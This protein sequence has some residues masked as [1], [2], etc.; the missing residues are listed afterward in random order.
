MMNSRKSWVNKALLKNIV[1]NNLFPAK[2]SLIIFVGFFILA[3]ISADGTGIGQLCIGLFGISAVVLTTVYPCFIQSFLINKTKSSMMKSIPLDSRTVWFTNYLAGYLIV[4]VTLLMEGIG[5]VFIDFT[6]SYNLVFSGNMLFRF[7]LM[8]FVL[9]F[10]YYTITFLVSSMAGNRLG[11]IVFSIVVYTLPVVLLGSFIVF[12]TYLVPG[13]VNQIENYYINMLFPLA[14]GL[15][16]ISIGNLTII[17]H[18]FIALALLGLSYYVYKNRDDEYIDEPLVFNKIGIVLKSGIVLIVTITVFYLILLFSHIDITFGIKGMLMLLTI[19]LIIGIIIA[20]FI[21]IIFKSQYIYRKLLIY[22]P[23]LLIFFGVNYIIANGQYYKAVNEVTGKSDVVGELYI[24]DAKSENTFTMNIEHTQLFDM[25]KYLND[26]RDNI[27]FEQVENSN[28]IIVFNLYYEGVNDNYHD[29]LLQY[30]FDQKLLIDYFKKHENAYLSSNSFNF[31]KES[32]LTCYYDNT[33]I[34]LNSSETKQLY[35]MTKEQNIVV[36]DFFNGE[37]IN[38]FGSSGNQYI[39]KVNDKFHE[40]LKDKKLIGQTEF[41][42]RCNKFIYD[43]TLLSDETDNKIFQ[44]VKEQLNIETFTLY[45][46]GIE[47]IEFDNNYVTY[48]MKLTIVD[49]TENH[50]ITLIIGLENEDD[51]IIIN[52]INR[53]AGE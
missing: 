26:N 40:F 49:E 4:L 6:R 18:C 35:Q 24:F 2:I 12:T 43:E 5:I 15:E 16:F 37:M 29:N 31:E 22:I 7:I 50:K 14:A 21:E 34:Y 39:L 9:L 8:I 10:I 48:S 13:A 30:Q 17:I 51:K 32:Y 33:E 27:H 42:N 38:L 23:V 28:S 1:K 45:D 41:I 25:I 52:S 19:Y 36:D 46:D 53:K 20:I 44:F 3:S 11:Q 47:L